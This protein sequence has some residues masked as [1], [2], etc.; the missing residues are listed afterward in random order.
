MNRL[1]AALVSSLFLLDFE[2]AFAFDA[3]YLS[4]Q[5]LDLSKILAPS[6]PPDSE[7]QK[8]D[9]AEVLLAQQKRTDSQAE[10]AIADN[11]LKLSRIVDEVFADNTAALRLS[12]FSAFMDRVLQ[13]T[14]AIFLA[15]KDVW[16]RPRP[17]SVSAEVKPIGELPATGSY[18]SGHATRGYLVAILLS[19]MVPEKRAQLFARGREY[20]ENRMIAGVHYPTDIEAGRLSATAIAA[21]LMQ[22]QRFMTD[23]EEAKTELRQA[24][25]LNTN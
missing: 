9:M 10:R 19:N 17:F 18:P 23:F 3:T 25:G 13:D 11:D 5:Q 6:P 20:G 12:K 8:R 14:R 7:L 2:V 4:T 21:A 24:L 15:S 22:E 16:K 1:F